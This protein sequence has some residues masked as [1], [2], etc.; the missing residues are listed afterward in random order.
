MDARGVATSEPRGELDADR[1]E[2]ARDHERL[3]GDGGSAA[4]RSRTNDVASS[5]RPIRGTGIPASSRAEASASGRDDVDA[6]RASAEA[7]HDM[8]AGAASATSTRSTRMKSTS[9]RFSRAARLASSRKSAERHAFPNPNVRAPRSR[10]SETGSP[11]IA[12]V[13]SEHHRARRCLDERAALANRGERGGDVVFVERA[14]PRTVFVRRRLGR[15]RLNRARFRSTSRRY[16][17]VAPP[18]PPRPRTLAVRPGARRRS[19]ILRDRR[20]DAKVRLGVDVRR[21][22]ATARSKDIH[23]DLSAQRRVDESKGV[24]VSAL[25]IVLAA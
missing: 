15:L 24:D 5:T 25:E 11:N 9:G 12:R 3:I 19:V 8:A 14:E 23:D 21:G 4:R 13:A 10:S 6:P 18:S 16:R 2:T 17:R 20:R 1:A 22:I 7:S